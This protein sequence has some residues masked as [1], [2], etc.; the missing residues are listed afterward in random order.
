MIDAK[1]NSSAS[2][3]DVRIY[4]SVAWTVEN[5]KK[6]T[7]F[8]INASYSHEFDYVSYG[9]G[10]NFAVK[11][12]NGNSE[13]GIKAQA[14]FDQVSLVYP[15][16]LIPPS[17]VSNASSEHEGHGRYPTSPR[18]TYTGSLSFSQVVTKNLQVMFLADF[19]SQNGYLSLPF[20]RVYFTNGDERVENLPN[21]RLKLPLGVRANYFLGDKI[22]LRS[23][24]RFY[25]DDWGLTSNTIDVETAIKITPF[26]SLSPFYRY[27]AQ[28]AIKY[29]TP[30]GQHSASETY[31]TSNYDLSKFRSDFFGAGIRFSPVNGVLGMQHVNMLEI[32]FGHYV[33]STDL[34]AN[35]VSLNVKFK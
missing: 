28:S 24:Y 20:H 6:G 17:T 11:S 33:R 18:N 14:Y 31:Y 16:E 8:G 22:V 30:Y 21:T 2:S 35:I 27:Y 5:E 34:N 4:P 3:H 13:L 1:A 32:R 15:K 12:K 19:V 10:T 29:F 26:M 9:L 23:F 7:T 25:K